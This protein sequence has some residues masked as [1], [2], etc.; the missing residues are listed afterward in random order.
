MFSHIIISLFDFGARIKATILAALVCVMRALSGLSTECNTTRVLY[1]HLGIEYD[2][3]QSLSRRALENQIGY[4][5][6]RE[7]RNGK[8]VTSF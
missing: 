1:I 2:K 6:N 7:D 8:E 3:R 5:N 4:D